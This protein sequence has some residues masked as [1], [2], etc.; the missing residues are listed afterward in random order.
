M[1]RQT[2]CADEN[3]KECEAMKIFTYCIN[4]LVESL[5]E[6]VNK[7]ITGK[8]EMKDI[9]FIITVPA[10]WDDT[11][12]MFMIEA[13]KNVSLFITAG[14]CTCTRVI[15]KFVDWCCKILVD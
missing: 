7:K 5:L 3:G 13:A 9:D 4:Y 10:I 15:K 2:V 8:L 6:S 12:K 11:A 14:F 1:N